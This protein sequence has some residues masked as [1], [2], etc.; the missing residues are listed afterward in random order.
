MKQEV[1]DSLLAR[2]SIR[3]YREEQIPE[4]VL[5]T[6]LRV[7]KHAPSAM[8]EQARHFTVVQDPDIIR[9]MTK[10]TLEQFAKLGREPMR[11]NMPF[12]LAPTVLVLSAPKEAAWG[13]ADVACAIMNFMQAAQAYGIGTCYIGAALGIHRP[14]IQKL[15]QIPQGYEPLACVTAGYAAE[16][17]A[18]S[19]PRREDDVTYLR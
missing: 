8:G 14:E 7:A 6:L 13:H 3:A 5:Q 10:A 11:P 16:E 17:P 18:P 12:Y 1:I 19:K 9:Q 4:D 15:L 2:R